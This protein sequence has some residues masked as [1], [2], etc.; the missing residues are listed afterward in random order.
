MNYEGHESINVQQLCDIHQQTIFQAAG[1]TR[2]CHIASV[3]HL[4]I[5]WR[6]RVSQN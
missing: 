5:V 1:V 3:K 2:W 6:N 4:F